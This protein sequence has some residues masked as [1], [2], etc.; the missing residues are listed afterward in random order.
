M[1]RY[2]AILRVDGTSHECEVGLAERNERRK[3]VIK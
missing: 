2:A 3:E 1:K